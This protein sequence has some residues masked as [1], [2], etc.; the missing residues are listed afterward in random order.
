MNTGCGLRVCPAR[1]RGCHVWD[2]AFNTAWGL[3]DLG[4]SSWGLGLYTSCLE[5]QHM[6]GHRCG[7]AV[8]AA[9][10]GLGTSS[11]QLCSP[12]DGCEDLLPAQ[13]SPPARTQ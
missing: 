6:G 8:A 2:L 1:V 10:F 11:N 12:R 9:Y 7:L 4:A 3:D 5:V 13:R